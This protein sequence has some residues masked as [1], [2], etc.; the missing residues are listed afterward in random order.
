MQEK[1]A[2]KLVFGVFEGFASPQ[3][4][5]PPLMTT[6]KTLFETEQRVAFYDQVKG[7]IIR[8]TLDGSEPDSTS[9]L[10]DREIIIDKSLTLKAR[11]FKEGWLPS[12]VFE[13]D[14]FK[15]NKTITDYTME[16]QPSNRYS[17]VHKLFD[18]EEGTT[19]FADGKWLGFS[20]NDL[21]FSTQLA[22][23]ES[24][25]NV[26]VSCMESIGGW[27]IYPKRVRVMGLNQQG[28]YEEIGR[29]DY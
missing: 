15:V 20:G 2:I 22:P 7:Q 11:I 14:F 13:E 18:F 23:G 28:A 8:Y 25:K 26:T 3:Q 19:N 24:I 12:D 17:G 27:I 16:T 10:F 21:V 1:T 4:L 6:E 9:T 5:K 29:Y